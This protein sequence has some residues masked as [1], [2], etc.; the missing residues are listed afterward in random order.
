MLKMELKY[1]GHLMRRKDSLEKSRMLGTIDGRRRRGRQRMRW[2]DGVTEAVGVSLG[3]LREMVE[4]RKAW[5]SVSGCQTLATGEKVLNRQ[6]GSMRSVS[7]VQRVALEFSGSVFPHAICLGDADNDSFSLFQLNELVV[8]DTSGRLFIYKN[9]E[10][11]PWTT[12]L[13]QGM[14]ERAAAAAAPELG[15][16]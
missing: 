9:D 7:Y 16:K 1:F 12:R 11:K 2:L 4:D 14:E 5:R 6:G 13:C 10:G 3:G 15:G 8:G